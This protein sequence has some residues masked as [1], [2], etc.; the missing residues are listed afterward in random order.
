MKGKSDCFVAA[1][2]SV[3]KSRGTLRAIIIQLPATE[4]ITNSSWPEL[5]VKVEANE[6]SV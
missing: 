4:Q 3:D 5:V 1:R 6:K 2:Y